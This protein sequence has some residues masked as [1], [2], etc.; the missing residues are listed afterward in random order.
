MLTTLRYKLKDRFQGK[1]RDTWRFFK[2]QILELLSK[3][4][5]KTAAPTSFA[6]LYMIGLCATAFRVL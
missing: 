6:S 3:A 2:A 1:S 5:A 4:C